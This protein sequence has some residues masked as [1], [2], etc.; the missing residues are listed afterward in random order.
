[1]TADPQ[2]LVDQF[3]GTGEAANKVPRGEAGFKERVDFGRII[4]TYVDP[5]TGVAVTTTK[6]I[7]VYAS[8]GVHIVPARP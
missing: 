2:R 8:D 1:M 3:A 4:G 7:I 6:G 5:S